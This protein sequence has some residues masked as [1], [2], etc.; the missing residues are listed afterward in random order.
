MAEEKHRISSGRKTILIGL[1]IAG[2]IGL[3][4]LVT[5]APRLQNSC[6]G[7][8]E[9]T[10]PRLKVHLEVIKSNG[11]AEIGQEK[12]QELS[13]SAQKVGL[14]LKTCCK[15]LEHGKLG[16]RQFQ[17]CIDTASAYERQIALVAKELAEVAEPNKKS[18]KDVLQEKG[19]SINDAIQAATSHVKNLSRQV[20]QIKP[21]PVPA[22]P[23]SAP[24]AIRVS[25]QVPGINAELVE[26]SRFGNTVTLKLRFVNAGTEDQKFSPARNLKISYEERISS[27][28]LD[29]ATGKRYTGTDRS[30]EYVSVLAGGSLEFWIKYVLPEGANP[31]YLT[32]VLNHGILLEHLEVP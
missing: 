21:P 22:K 2:L 28:L 6:E 20:A 3:G 4:V 18:G 32:A 5:L 27:Y 26:F 1:A 23:T 13:E 24:P 7:I 19:A 29:E 9:Q 11:A 14:H 17:R 15:V 30:N 31:R 8:L 12:I 16:P 25:S 10:A